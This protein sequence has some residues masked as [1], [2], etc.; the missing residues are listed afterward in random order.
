MAGTALVLALLLGASPVRSAPNAQTEQ[1]IEHLIG[2][3]SRSDVTFVR[4]TG[5]YTPGE[6][7]EHMLKKY[8]HFRDDITTPGDFIE[9]CATK[10]LLS[11]KPYRVIDRQGNTLPTSDWLRAELAT[12]QVRNPQA[13]PGA[14]GNNE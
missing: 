14:S 6:A 2:Y 8:R 7:A 5:E 1:T 12:W 4:N 11:G 10:S 13:A 3:V 9:L